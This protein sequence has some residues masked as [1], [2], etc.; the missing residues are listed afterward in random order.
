MNNMIECY[1]NAVVHH[2]PEKDR[3]EV[4]E[5]LRA[6]IYDMLSENPSDEEVK[7]VLYTLGKPSKLAEKYRHTPR[8]LISPNTYDE[9]IRTLKWVLP[10]I[11]V[12]FIVVGSVM[13]VLSL[14]TG[15]YE[16]LSTTM[17]LLK[18]VSSII[19]LGIT[20]LL[21]GLF[22]ITFGFVIAER[23]GYRKQQK[24]TEDWKIEDLL[25]TSHT[26]KKEIPLSDILVGVVLTTIFTIVS[27]LVCLGIIPFPI[28]VYKGAVIEQICNT[29]FLSSC[30]PA[31]VIM[32]A[33]AI[34]EYITKLVERHWTSVVCIG[35]VVSNLVSMAAWI[36]IISRPSIFSKEFLSFVET[37][38]WTKYN[39]VPFVN[40]G[41]M[42]S[43]LVI[44]IVVCTILSCIS[45]IY[46]TI[47][48]KK[49]V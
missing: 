23:T 46:K 33:F 14:I 28:F 35:V 39:I 21:H 40:Q 8:Y 30:I 1:V 41:N 49:L 15:E 6:N 18:I 44:I 11:V 48:S 4:E 45:V 36:Y 13:E 19:S 27:I 20:G 34:G 31:F 37:N 17:I 16:K 7:D 24:E 43:M 10:L 42:V 38:D 47:K 22:Y 3:K 29:E 12:T 26:D 32:G 2:L 9:Y 25:E 5:E